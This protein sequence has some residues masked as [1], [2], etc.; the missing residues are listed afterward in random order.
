[1]IISD[2]HG[3][4]YELNKVL[5]IYIKEK[6]N[7]LIILGDLFNYGIDLNKEDITNRLNLLKDNIVAVR[8]NCD[9]NINNI[10][11]DMPYINNI[12][13]NNKTIT[14]THGHMYTKEYLLTLNS[15]IIFVGH[16]HIADI[17]N[18]NNKILV[19]PGSISKSRMGKNSFA[20]IND[21][22]ISIRNLENIEFKKY[23]F[24]K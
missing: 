6:C 11:F 24:Y 12:N 10:L 3:G 15:D 14:I 5:D 20:L 8:G 9:I 19:N 2:I 22:Y 21:T 1:M 7:K 13:F 17:S 18:I 23:I 16:S 4:I